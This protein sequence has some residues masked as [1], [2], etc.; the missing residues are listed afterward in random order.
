MQEWVDIATRSLS[1]PERIPAKLYFSPVGKKRKHTIAFRSFA[2]TV[3]KDD[4]K[5]FLEEKA[6]KGRS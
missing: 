5:A 3:D 4:L 6:E 1:Q 2:Y